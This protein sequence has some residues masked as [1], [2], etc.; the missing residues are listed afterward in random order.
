MSE[1]E[2]AVAQ[3]LFANFQYEIYGRGLGGETPELPVAVGEL[4]AARARC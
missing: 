2:P 1:D 3:Q 4:E